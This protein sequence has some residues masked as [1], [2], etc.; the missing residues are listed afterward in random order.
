MNRMPPVQ[1]RKE[2]YYMKRITQKRRLKKSIREVLQVILVGTIGAVMLIAMFIGAVLQES[3]K[4][5]PVMAAEV[6]E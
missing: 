4:L 3:E 5:C 1:R 2:L 6:Q